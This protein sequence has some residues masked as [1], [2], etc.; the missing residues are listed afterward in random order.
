MRTIEY[1][2]K[3]RTMKAIR[4]HEFGGPEV[5]KLE[6]I[7]VP[8]PCRGEIRIRVIAAGVNPADWKMRIGSMKLPLPMTMGLDVA[9]VV[10]A[11]GP[12]GEDFSYGEKVF[13]KATT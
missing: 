3:W 9:G 10:D 12:G 5:L 11:V 8:Q 7:P 1:S 4:I 2:V 6:D 13:A